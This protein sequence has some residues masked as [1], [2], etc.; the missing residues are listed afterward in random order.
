[1]APFEIA[2]TVRHPYAE[3]S[4]LH[5]EFKETPFVIPSHAAA[6]VPFR[7]MLKKNAAGDAKKK[8]IGLKDT[9]QLGYIPER[10][11]VLRERSG[12]EVKTSWVQERDN[13]LV[14]LDT[15][16]GAIE[17][18]ISL[19]FFYAKR[20]P[21][22]EDNRR[23]IIGVG[24]VLSVRPHTEYAYTTKKPQLRCVLWERN[25]V[26]SIRP[27][28]ADGFLFPYR[29]LLDLSEQ[30]PSLRP[31]DYVAFAPNDFF[32]EYSYGSELL[33]HDGAIAS[34]IAC[35]ATMR[36]IKDR[37]PGPWEGAIA[38]IDRELNR[39]WKAR[40]AFP[41]LG[42]ALCAFGL[43]QG[44]LIAYEIA[45][46]QAKAKKEWTENPWDLVDAV[47]DDPSILPGGIAATIGSTF[48]QKWKKLKKERRALL[49]LLS[50]SA[51]SS[52]QAKRFWV[53]SE[54]DKADLA[55]SDADLLG[56]LYRAYELDRG[57]LDPVELGTIDRGLFP[58]PVVQ[59]GRSPLK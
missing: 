36:K 34:L 28:F 3:W 57:S 2:R 59:S 37:V 27:D 48:Q 33:P 40:G 21:L 1:M 52:D 44:N 54:R 31:E 5:E 49:E 6:C 43:E 45:N 29:E 58:D 9:L 10:E 13:Q 42:S 39:L 22:A 14:L 11:P 55:V 18:S 25:V 12:R 35:A 46:A 30:D 7:W 51:L 32:E 20:T 41:G 38:W 15:F 17:P 26:H 19:C 24:R 47:F 8:V 16:F 4:V 53:E 56:N 50:R 23:V